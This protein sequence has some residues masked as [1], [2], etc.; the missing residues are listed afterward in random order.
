MNEDK[1]P[2]PAVGDVYTADVCQLQFSEAAS[3][4]M[5]IDRTEIHF[6][7]YMWPLNLFTFIYSIYGRQ[8]KWQKREKVNN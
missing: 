3:L 4:A 5:F 1:A 6:D 2:P 7:I 8:H